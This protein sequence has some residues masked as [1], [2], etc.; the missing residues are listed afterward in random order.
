MFQVEEEQQQQRQQQQQQHQ[1]LLRE[2]LVTD[3]QDGKGHQIVQDASKLEVEDF[4][5][6][7]CAW[8]VY[9]KLGRSLTVSSSSDHQARHKSSQFPCS[10]VKLSSVSRQQQQQQ[11]MMICLLVQRRGQKAML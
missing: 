1:C 7:R 6:P 10:K 9:Q 5:T 11:V 3:H 8:T 2:K 4:V